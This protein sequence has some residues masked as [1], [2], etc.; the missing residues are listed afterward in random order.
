M[1]GV[2]SDYDLHLLMFREVKQNLVTLHSCNY[3]TCI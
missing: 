3:G 1:K 2:F